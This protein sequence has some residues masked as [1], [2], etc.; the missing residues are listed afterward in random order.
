MYGRFSFVEK[1]ALIV[2]NL[3]NTSFEVMAN[4]NFS[5]SQ[6]AATVQ[7]KSTFKQAF[8]HQCCLYQMK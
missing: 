1:I 6:V 3:F 7:T 2:S 4:S 5:P 8:Q